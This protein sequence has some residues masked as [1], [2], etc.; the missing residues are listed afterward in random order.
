MKLGQLPR[1][2]DDAEIIADILGGN[3]NAFE[4][5]LDRY[6]QF[7]AQIVKKH[8]PRDQA[9]EVAHEIFVRTYQSLPGFKGTKPFKHWLSKIAVRCCYDFWRD[10]YRRQETPVDL[11]FAETGPA[12]ETAWSSEAQ[13][14]NEE[15]FEAK[16]LI[17]RALGRVSAADRMVLTLTYL[18]EYSASEAAQLM[19]WSVPRV[20]IQ[21]YRARS[22]LRK[23]LTKMLYQGRS[24]HGTDGR[25]NR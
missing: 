7:V 1:S 9:P 6:Q 14:R 16:D 20:K 5:L 22:R 17:Q 23:I 4:L 12:L 25:K 13:E 21:S 19:G 2:P 10:H 3:I 11:V 15:Q 8:V 18:E 24:A